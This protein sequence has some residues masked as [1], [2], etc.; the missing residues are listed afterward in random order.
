MGSQDFFKHPIFH[1]WLC[2]SINYF[3]SVADT[4]TPHHPY[5]VS[6]VAAYIQDKWL[7]DSDIEMQPICPHLNLY[8]N[9]LLTDCGWSPHL[10]YRGQS[11]SQFMAPWLRL[12]LG[13]TPLHR[14]GQGSRGHQMSCCYWGRLTSMGRDSPN[15]FFPFS[16][17]K[18]TPYLFITSSLY[19]RE[20][21]DYELLAC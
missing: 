21:F 5:G 6:K 16:W 8:Q 14:E 18:M 1:C 3:I 20:G 12:C 13:V 2:C 4:V 7:S 19:S 10:V 17:L 11:Q 15:T 9:D